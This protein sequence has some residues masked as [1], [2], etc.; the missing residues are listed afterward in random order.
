M[1]ESDP[2][3]R[4]TIIGAGRVGTAL[5]FL[6][7]Q[8]GYRIEGV[9]SRSVMSAK[10]AGELLEAPQVILS[11]PKWRDQSQIIILSTPDREIEKVANTLASQGG[12]WKGKRIIRCVKDGC[13]RLVCSSSQR[14]QRAETSQR[15]Y[16]KL[17]QQS[18]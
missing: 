12:S 18:S 13:A 14:I 2:K 10:R 1:K 9:A 8:K 7:K 16:H 3:P 17:A 15:E 5:G 11:S 6:L 4:I